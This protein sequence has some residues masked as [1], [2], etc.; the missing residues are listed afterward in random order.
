MNTFFFMLWYDTCASKDHATHESSYDVR[1]GRPSKFLP[2][3]S[4][5]KERKQDLQDKAE[6]KILPS[7]KEGGHGDFRDAKT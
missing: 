6:G 3:Q 7:C 2:Q 5:V 1:T 4:P